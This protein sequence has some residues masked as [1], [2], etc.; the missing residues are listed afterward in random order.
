MEGF[1][2]TMT[3]FRFLQSFSDDADYELV[4]N[5]RVLICLIKCHIM[6]NSICTRASDSRNFLSVFTDF[7]KEG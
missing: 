6:T 7:R 2:V 1:L 3:Q 5:K 4:V